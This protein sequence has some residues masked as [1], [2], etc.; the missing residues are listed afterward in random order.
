MGVLV[1][2]RKGCENI[3]C[4][5][6]SHTHGYL[7]WECKEE[8][9]EFTDGGIGDFMHSEK[10]SNVK[11]KDWTDIVSDEFKSRYEEE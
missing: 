1:C 9:E 10:H 5:F 11:R 3:M 6:Y 2:N 4:D 8:L 7:C